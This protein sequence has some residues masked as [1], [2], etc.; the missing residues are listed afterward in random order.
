M[1]TEKWTAVVF[2]SNGEFKVDA[3]MN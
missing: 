2:E 1:N 3:V